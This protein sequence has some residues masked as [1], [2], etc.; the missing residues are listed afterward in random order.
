MICKVSESNIVSAS[1]MS[2]FLKGSLRKD[3][4]PALYYELTRKRSDKFDTYPS[5]TRFRAPTNC[6][7][8]WHCI[9][10]TM[11]TR[12]R[13]EKKKPL[14]KGPAFPLYT[15]EG[16]LIKALFHAEYIDYERMA[17]VPCRRPLPRSHG[18]PSSRPAGDRA[19]NSALGPALFCFATIGP[20]AKHTAAESNIYQRLRLTISAGLPRDPKPGR[21]LSRD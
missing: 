4:C 3:G 18:V 11:Q 20:S 12:Q 13:K 16:A 9:F 19:E 21:H 8:L 14:A 1:C 2:V 15:W 5:V 10:Y 6:H 7:F 17:G